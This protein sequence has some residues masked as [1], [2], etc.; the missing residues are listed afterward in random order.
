MIGKCRRL[1]PFRA[2][3]QT[4]TLA[5]PA[6]LRLD[7]GSEAYLLSAIGLIALSTRQDPQPCLSPPGARQ[8]GQETLVSPSRGTPRANVLAEKILALRFR[9]YLG[10]LSGQ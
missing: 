8:N 7:L 4:A 9:D 1:P 5:T 3:S 10:R 6:G 2:S